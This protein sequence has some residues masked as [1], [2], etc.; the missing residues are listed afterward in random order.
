MT[1]FYHP[2]RNPQANTAPAPA[3]GP[4]SALPPAHTPS[5][6]PRSPSVPAVAQAK[7]APLPPVRPGHAHSNRR[8]RQHRPHLKQLLLIERHHAK[9]AEIIR[10]RTMIMP[11]KPQ[12][13]PR[14]LHHP[15]HLAALLQQATGKPGILALAR[16]PKRRLRRPHHTRRQTHPRMSQHKIRPAHTR[17]LRIRH[18]LLRAPKTSHSQTHRLVNR[19]SPGK[20]QSAPP[21]PKHRLQILQRLQR[22]KTRPKATRLRRPA[23]ETTRQIMI[24]AQHQTPATR[25]CQLL[26]ETTKGRRQRSIDRQQ[27]EIPQHHQRRT[28]QRL[29]LIITQRTR[30]PVQIT[31]YK[32]AL[33]V[34]K[35]RHLPT[36]IP[37]PAAPAQRQIRTAAN[38][39]L[40]ATEYRPNG[41]TGEKAH[42]ASLGRCVRK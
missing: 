11:A 33:P 24:T 14:A 6:E 19:M 36:I 28:A 37:Q 17:I 2:P 39:R 26:I 13:C 20:H 1:P 29:H 4:G 12:P 35:I 31:H 32:Q 16:T 34:R 15:Q 22:S 30:A 25:S 10:K 41:V 21:A 42:V 7:R 40:T 27:A 5:R 23:S 8:I 9:I 3:A 38:Q 18:H